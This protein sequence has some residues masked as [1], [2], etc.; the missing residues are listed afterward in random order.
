[1]LKQ[2]KHALFIML[3]TAVLLVLLCSWNYAAAIEFTRESSISTCG[4]NAMMKNVSY[5][6]A[7]IHIQFRINI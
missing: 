2:E 1:M 3:G 5:T 7:Q 4:F 6:L